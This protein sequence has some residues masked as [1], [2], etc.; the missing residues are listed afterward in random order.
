M[1]DNLLDIFKRCSHTS[2]PYILKILQDS[3]PEKTHMPIS[4]EVMQLLD[5]PN[6][7]IDSDSDSDNSDIN[8]AVNQ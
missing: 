2:D 4:P 8:M 7:I 1:Q 3:L 6:N 5:D